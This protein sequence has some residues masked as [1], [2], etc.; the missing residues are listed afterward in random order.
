MYLEEGA[1]EAP[2]FI[3]SYKAYGFLGRVG[4]RVAAL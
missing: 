1:I 3:C 4:T 2:F